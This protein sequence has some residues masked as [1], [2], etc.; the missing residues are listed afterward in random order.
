[1]KTGC[2]IA[3]FLSLPISAVAQAAA[4]AAIATAGS[5]TAGAAAQG[6]GKSI[7]GVFNS[8]N[9]TLSKIKDGGPPGSPA[10]PEETISAQTAQTEPAIEAPKLDPID[11]SA[12]KPGMIRTDLIAKLGS[13][14]LKI[15]RNDGP[16][17]I[18]TLWYER[19]GQPDTVIRLKNGLV[20]R[21][22]ASSK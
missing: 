12:I 14:S 4:E 2:F 15:T 20:E 18:E 9:R 1:V 19:S 7:G 5:A 22:E 21:I 10:K 17:F 11:K 8:L 6:A 3:V 16:A 13:P